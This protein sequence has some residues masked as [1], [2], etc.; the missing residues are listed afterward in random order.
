MRI[1]QL[2]I[3]SFGHFV[4]FIQRPEQMRTAEQFRV[5]GGHFGLGARMDRQRAVVFHAERGNLFQ[6]FHV[7]KQAGVIHEAERNA[8]GA[9]LQVP[10]HKVQHLLFFV[11]R[12]FLRLAARDAGARGA[13]AGQFRHVAGH[14]LVYCGGPV[15][16]RGVR[17]GRVV[18][19]EQTG[20][21]FVHMRGVVGKADGRNAAVAGDEGRHALPNERFK[22]FLRVVFNGK[23]VVVGVAVNEP[24][25]HGLAGQVNDLVGGGLVRARADRQNPVVFK[26]YAAHVGLVSGA[27]IYCSVFQQCLHKKPPSCKSSSSSILCTIPEKSKDPCSGFARVLRIC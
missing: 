21:D 18:K 4:E 22:V 5:A 13:V 24:R 7:R 17:S 19:V 10:L 8:G 26:Q 27:V 1:L 15:V 23:P 3:R 11:R 2:Q 6:L 12:Q 14:V 20:A 9:L 25:R 16:E